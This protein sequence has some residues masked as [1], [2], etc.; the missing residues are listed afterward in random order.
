MAWVLLCGLQATRGVLDVTHS[1]GHPEHGVQI[2][3]WDPLARI[4]VQDAGPESKWLNIDSQ[5]VTAVLRYDGDP[6]SV[7]W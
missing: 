3:R 5:V 1:R 4:T 6:S 2:E 7:G